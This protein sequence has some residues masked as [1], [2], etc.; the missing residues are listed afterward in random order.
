MD[1]INFLLTLEDRRS[2]WIE[3][4]VELSFASE[5]WQR[6]VLARKE[7]STVYIRRHFE[8][9]VFSYLAAELKS[10]DICIKGS[11]TFAD[12]REQL[13]PWSECESLL[14]DYLS[15]INRRHINLS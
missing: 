14:V 7:G 9:C 12:Y 10:G 6:T 3:A 15:F 4:K 2:E 5:L 13:L 8:V 1:A 11:G